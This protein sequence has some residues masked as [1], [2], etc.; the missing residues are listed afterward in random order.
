MDRIT[1]TWLRPLLAVVPGILSRPLFAEL[2]YD[3]TPGVT[4][5]SQDV[6]HLHRL[7]LYTCTA[8]G[9]GVFIFML[10]AVLKHRKST[11][12]KAAQFHES[13]LIE[14]TWTII[15]FVIL[16]LMAIPATRVLKNM[17]DTRESA[18]TI[19]VT[20]RQWKWHYEY[21]I[22]END[23]SLKLSFESQL[24]TPREA[25]ETPLRA[26]GLFPLGLANYSG[27]APKATNKDVNYL[28]EVDK[29]VVI[30]TGKKIRFLITADDV[31]HSWYVPEFGVKRDAIPGF[32]NEIWTLVPEGKE[33]IYRGQCTEL[34]GKGHGFMPIVV[35]ARRPAD[36]EQW[37]ADSQ[38]AQR[39]AAE[40]AANSVDATFAM[41]TLLEEGEQAYLT[42]C[43]VC[44]QPN[45]QGGGAIPAL[46]QADIATQ[47]ERIGEHINVVRNGR[48]AMPAFKDLLPPKTLAAIIT[49]ERNAWGNNTGQLVQ[50]KDVVHDQ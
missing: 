34:C 31:I 42:T 9:A 39:I 46:A 8:I 35:D 38:E 24:S 50:P 29:P 41:E 14:L 19:K 3:L 25:Y 30:P 27:E 12:H 2:Q 17:V 6:F 20:G 7:M 10:Y 33:G 32:I 22:Y 18:L 36:F 45:G 21:L 48:N 40:E 49:Y 37:L 4:Q 44:H 15:P 5:I 43:A 11:G 1:T 28:L 13:T 23:N 16:I 47:P 26:S